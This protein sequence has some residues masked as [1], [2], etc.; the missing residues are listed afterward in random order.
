MALLVI[1]SIHLWL[2]SA[3]LPECNKMCNKN[4]GLVVSDAQLE[5]GMSTP[6]EITNNI[7]TA[8]AQMQYCTITLDLVHLQTLCAISNHLIKELLNIEKCLEYC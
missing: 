5:N 4:G 1:T 8:H 2:Y 7:L 3:V 6:Q